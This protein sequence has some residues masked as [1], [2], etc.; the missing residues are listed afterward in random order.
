MAHFTFNMVAR[1]FVYT[2]R[3]FKK[4]PK[5]DAFCLNG[6]NDIRGI[7]AWRL[8]NFVLWGLVHGLLLVAHRFGSELSPI[9][10]IFSKSKVFAGIFSWLITQYLI[11]FTWLI[12]RIENTDVL[13]PAMKTFLTIN[14]H[15]DSEE[16]FEILP[17][18]KC[19]AKHHSH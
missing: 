13:L 6:Y 11:F 8:L 14:G 7:M 18:I 2:T 3:R 15:F 1:L 4:W 10:W 5:K 17:E 16:F 9:K 19:K 12:F